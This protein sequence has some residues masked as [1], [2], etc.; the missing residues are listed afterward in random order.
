LI[1]IFEYLI[2]LGLFICGLVSLLTIKYHLIKS[3]E[4]VDNVLTKSEE[5]SEKIAKENVTLFLYCK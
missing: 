4:E 1:I 5:T 2:C 3:N